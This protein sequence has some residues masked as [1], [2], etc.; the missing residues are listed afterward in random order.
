MGG[1]LKLRPVELWPLRLRY[2]GQYSVTR[3]KCELAWPVCA[4]HNASAKLAELQN[5]HRNRRVLEVLLINQ[6]GANK[7]L[8]FT[9]S[10]S[11]GLDIA[12]EGHADG[13]VKVDRSIDI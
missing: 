7:G 9:R 13:S 12:E 1:L 10:S 3:L 4:S 8:E 6:L 5:V 2:E 11:S